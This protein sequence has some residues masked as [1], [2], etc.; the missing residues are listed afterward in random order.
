VALAAD[1][2]GAG[3]AKCGAATRRAAAGQICD[4]W[5]VRIPLS[6]ISSRGHSTPPARPRRTAPA[7]WHPA[8]RRNREVRGRAGTEPGGGAGGGGL[9]AARNAPLLTSARTIF[10]LRPELSGRLSSQSSNAD[11]DSNPAHV[12]C[13]RIST[14]LHG[15]H[16]GRRRNGCAPHPIVCGAE[17][18]HFARALAESTS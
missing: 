10:M 7:A 13:P 9:R 16:Q 12:P 6:F 14:N 11:C 1:L 3:P 2:R 18:W 4:Q 5:N 15:R 17:A 8:R